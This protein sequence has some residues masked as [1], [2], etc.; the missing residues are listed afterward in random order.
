[1]FR[2]T[3]VHRI[4]RFAACGLVL[5]AIGNA[6]QPDV[7]V[8]DVGVDFGNTNDIHY[9][10][11][12]GGIAAYNIATQS[13]N[14]GNAQ[15]D[16][17]DA[18]GDTRHPV[19]SQ[20]MFRLK[21]GRFEHL[22]QSWLKHGFC[23]VNEFEI[24]CS[25]CGSTSCDTLGIGCADTYWATL[26]DGAGG[27]S[28]RFVNATTGVHSDGTPAPAGPTVI[29]GRLQ[30][31]VADIDPAQNNGA[32]YFIEGHYITA[33]D[34]AAGNDFNNA[35]WR[36]VN[37]V[38]VSN[39]NGGGSTHRQEP[40][41]YA[42]QDQDPLVDIVQVTNT[43]S[44]TSTLYL[45]GCRVTLIG[46]NTWAYEYAIQ[47]LN[48]DQSANSFRLPYGNGTTISNI[49]FHDVDYHSGDPYALTDWTPIDTGN[50]VLWDTASFGS[51]PNANAIRW[52]TLYNFR[53]EAN[54]QP[55]TGTATIGLFKPGT[56]STLSVPGLKVPDEP[57]AVCGTAGSVATR[58]G[59]SN[60]LGYTASA[61][62]PGLSV[63]FGV[64]GFYNL[65]VVIAY[66]G[67][68]NLVLGN[69]QALLID[70]ASAPL[71]S[72]NLT[73]LPIGQASTTVPN[74]IALCGATAYT[75]AVLVGPTGPGPPFQ[76]YNSQDLTVGF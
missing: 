48:S 53:F 6:Q 21:D 65:G 56:N 8:F 72:L 59:G 29:R 75:Q 45:V 61:P 10:G 24:G 64:F 15:L 33:D 73:G 30:V 42:W 9:W 71:F 36:R 63:S 66:N 1:M 25:P 20:N 44:G 3:I 32:E 58:N 7:I 47:N 4:L 37:V 43:E 34:A 49:G 5:G 14:I 69:G 55:T 23:A 70:P 62:V 13:C 35:S 50:T 27:R 52:G 40:G 41:I 74:D 54:A 46:S 17:F 18:G 16:W 28:K 2:I 68:A 12:S 11:Q 57:G 38:S 39:V 19:I 76:L 31:A 26:N 67:P 60:P 22:G 51:D